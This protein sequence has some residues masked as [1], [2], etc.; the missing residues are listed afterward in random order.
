MTTKTLNLLLV[1]D[2]QEDIDLMKEALKE[3]AIP[4]DVHVVK[5]GQDAMDFLRDAANGRPDLILLDLNMPKKNG[6]QVLKEIKND[7]VLK[8]IPVIVLTTSRSLTDIMECYQSHCNCYICKPIELEG[9]FKVA[10]KIEEF[11]F[12]LAELPPNPAS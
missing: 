8:V 9:F 4:S 12:N 7:P 3:S 6:R 5:N 10:R 11:W 2:S 1:E